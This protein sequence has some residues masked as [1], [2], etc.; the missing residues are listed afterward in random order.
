M[1]QNPYWNNTNNSW[2][3]SGMTFSYSS[4]AFSG[5]TSIMSELSE[6]EIRQHKKKELKSILEGDDELL[7]EVI[8]ELRR[9]KIENVKDKMK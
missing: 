2:T 7:Q 9:K 4:G 1:S 3:S 8:S 5:A 6:E